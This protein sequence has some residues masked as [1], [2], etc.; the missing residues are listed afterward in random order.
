M[1]PS[2]ATPLLSFIMQ[3]ILLPFLAL[4]STL[5]GDAFG[6]GCSKAS[7]Q[8]LS[9]LRGTAHQPP[10]SLLA[11]HLWQFPVITLGGNG[12]GSLFDLFLGVDGGQEDLEGRLADVIASSTLGGPSP[13]TSTLGLEVPE[14]PNLSALPS[15]SGYGSIFQVLLPNITPS[16]AISV[17]LPYF[18]CKS[19][20]WS[21]LQKERLSRLQEFEEQLYAVKQCQ[22]REMK[23]LAGQIS[24]LEQQ[25]HTSI[26]TREW[27]DEEQ[28]VFTVSLQDE[29]K[30]V[31]VQYDKATPGGTEGSHG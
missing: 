26:E 31:Q 4:N 30:Q 22:I 15:L 8:N 14:T 2:H 16:P 13:N 3:L 12:R 20:R 21:I 29:L 6:S 19:L 17:L 18:T 9:P 1:S 5:F 7:S 11:H 24:V 10:E 27:V 25:L 23:E 28:A